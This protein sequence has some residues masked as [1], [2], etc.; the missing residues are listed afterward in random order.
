[1]KCFFDKSL[2]KVVR[3]DLNTH[4]FSK[5]EILY[6][7]LYRV[8]FRESLAKVW[9]KLGERRPSLEATVCALCG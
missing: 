8:I 7:N 5:G 6:V 3:Y 1:M 4:G 9:I 2:A